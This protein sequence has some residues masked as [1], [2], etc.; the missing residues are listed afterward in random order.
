MADLPANPFLKPDWMVSFG[1]PRMGHSASLRL[2]ASDQP[3]V[4]RT[5]PIVMWGNQITD[6]RRADRSVELVNRR[7]S[8]GRPPGREALGRRTDRCSRQRRK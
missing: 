5:T 8:H 1:E 4:A 2:V 7:R 6:A 3:E